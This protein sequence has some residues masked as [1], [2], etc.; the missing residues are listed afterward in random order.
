MEGVDL[1][2]GLE[3][4]AGNRRLYRDLLTQFAAKQGSAARQ[5]QAALERGDRSQAERLAHS[6]KGAAGNL[7]IQQIFHSAGKLETAIRESQ[8]TVEEMIKELAPAL[9]RQAQAIQ[10]SLA[11]T[12]ATTPRAPRAEPLEVSAAVARLKELLEASDADAPQAYRHLAELLAGTVAPSDL[13]A[14]EA[15]VNTFDFETALVKLQEIAERTL[16]TGSN[17]TKGT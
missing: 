10:Q 17:K 9:E 12:P 1:P 7:G 6:L 4:V 14:L 3:R 2:G 16:R 5:I 15:A 11:T 8:P 13:K